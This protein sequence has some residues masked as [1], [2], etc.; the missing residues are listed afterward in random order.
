MLRES[1]TEMGV[2]GGQ[3]LAEGSAR[4]KALRLKKVL[5]ILKMEEDQCAW[6]LRKEGVE[7]NRKVAQRV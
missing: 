2:G 5:H 4:A 1:H 3:D 6:T 7:S